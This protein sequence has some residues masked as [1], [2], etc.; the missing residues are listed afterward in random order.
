MTRTTVNFLLD[1]ALLAVFLAIA[2]CAVV[3]RFVFPPA[4]SAAQWKLWARRTMSGP[5]S[6]SRPCVFSHWPYWCTSRCTGLGY[7]ASYR[8]A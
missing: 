8:P 5:S 7:A 2:F 4:T 1:C 6:N 3:L